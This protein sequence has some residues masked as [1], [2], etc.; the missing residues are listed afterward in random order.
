MSSFNHQVC[1]RH[2]FPPIVPSETLLPAFHY[3]LFPVHLMLELTGIPYVQQNSIHGGT[4]ASRMH[5]PNPIKGKVV[6]AC[7]RRSGDVDATVFY[8]MDVLRDLNW[9]RGTM[10]ST[11]THHFVPPIPAAHHTMKSSCNHLR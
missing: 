3:A 4:S 5:P 2:R 9:S 8:L 6:F 1:Y 11:S 7:E 10:D